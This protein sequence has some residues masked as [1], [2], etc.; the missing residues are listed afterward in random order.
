MASEGATVLDDVAGAVQPKA[1]V[2][3]IIGEPFSEEQKTLI[4]AEVTKGRNQTF[5]SLKMINWCL[6]NAV[7]T[8]EGVTGWLIQTPSAEMK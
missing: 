7:W 1:A 2:L 5:S 8:G 3:L 4:L 6:L